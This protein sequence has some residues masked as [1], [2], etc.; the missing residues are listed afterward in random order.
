MKSLKSLLLDETANRRA[1]EARLTLGMQAVAAAATCAHLQKLLRLQMQE[2]E[3][4][5]RKIGEIFRVLGEAPGERTCQV[6]VELLS[7]AGR[8]AAA[9]KDSPAINAALLCVAQTIKH[10]EIA[11]YGCLREWASLLGNKEATGLFDELLDEEK[12]ANQALIKLAR[13]RCNKKALG[14][15]G[16]G[17]GSSDAYGH[18]IDFAVA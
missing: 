7:E 8:R 2:T 11:S 10:H 1:S 16:D 6:T 15:P 14:P 18:K 3:G 5:V 12:T 13:F 4:H 9:F 17:G